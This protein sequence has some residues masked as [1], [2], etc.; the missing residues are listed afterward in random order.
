MPKKFIKT[1]DELTEKLVQP[2]GYCL[3]TDRILI[4][5][6]S[7]GYMYR[8]EPDEPNDSGWRFFSGDEDEDYLDNSENIGLYDVNTIAHYDKK[9]IPL[10]NSQYNTSF[11]KNETN[12][13]EEEPFN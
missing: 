3:A 9:I 1:P 13:F 4:D 5:G 8:E 7:I 2:M 6:L 10:L 12:E 11:V